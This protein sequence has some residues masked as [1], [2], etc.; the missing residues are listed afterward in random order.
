MS[1]TKIIRNIDSAI[2]NHVNV[3]IYR[4]TPGP[5]GRFIEV[6]D[7]LLRMF[8]YASKK[9]FL[10]EVRPVDI[11][12]YPHQRKKFSDLLIRKGFVNYKELLLKRRD[13]TP[14]H[15]NVTAAAVKDKKGKVKWFDG[16][17]E[18]VSKVKGEKERFKLIFEHSPIAI[19]EEDFSAFAKVLKRLRQQGIKDIRRYLALHKEVV[20]KTFRKIKILDVN[21]AALSLYGAK[22]KK[23]LIAN[24]GKTFAKEAVR[25][26]IDEFVAL[27]EGKKIFQAEFKSKTLSGQPY[28]VFL[29]VSVPDG[30]EKS[31]SRVIVTLQD[32]SERKR[33]EQHLKNMAQQDGLTKLLNSR[34]ISKRLE[35][36]LIRA[37]RYNL[38]LSCLMLDVD[39][40]KVVNDRFGH[41]KGDQILKRVAFLIKRGLRRTDIIGRYGGDEFFII[42]TETKPENAGIAAERVR[43]IISSM[44]FK[45]QSRDAIKITVS[46]GISGYPSDSIKDFKDLI[47][48]ADKALYSAK[49]S[50]RDR[51]VIS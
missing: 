43:K 45:S 23:E 5:E 50:G 30:Y 27:S 22:T 7:T 32:I 48:Q 29:K 14:I 9:E 44:T 10:K 8:G 49:A 36:E 31:F 37:K 6:T 39:Y 12:F 2:F 20:I 19:W 13:G 38:N 28:D 40:F 33:L 18:D 4:N 42:L 24:F 47:A 46:V 26:L 34:A 17:I 35:E 16:V 3:G 1:K 25:T 15:A 41:Q 51:I 21:R 11:Y